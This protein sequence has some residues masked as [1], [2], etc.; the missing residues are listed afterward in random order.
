MYLFTSV[1]LSM[2]VPTII[3][4]LSFSDMRQ[5]IKPNKN[6][7]LG[8]LSGRYLAP[9]PIQKVSI[10]PYFGKNSALSDKKRGSDIGKLLVKL[11]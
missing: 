5:T 11:G 4:V 9:S 10:F 7:V 1:E 8:L 3:S 6:Y 2:S